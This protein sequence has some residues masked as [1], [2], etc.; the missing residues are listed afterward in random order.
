MP[1]I[2]DRKTRVSALLKGEALKDRNYVRDV[3]TLDLTGATEAP[4]IG[5]CYNSADGTVIVAAD[6]SGFSGSIWILVD[7]TIYTDWVS[8]TTS[9]NL[10]VLTG[11]PG[12][13]GFAEVVR[14]E[15]KFGDGLSAGQIDSI[16]AVI[17]S[18]GIRVVNAY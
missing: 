14:E 15:L 16:V 13:S 6:V 7:D 18:Q 2:A 11:G 17:E 4:E 12:G 3:K 9:Y 5:T 10:A 1:K 8:G